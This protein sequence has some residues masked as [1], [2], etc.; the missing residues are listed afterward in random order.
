MSLTDTTCRQ[1]KPTDKPYKLADGTL[2]VNVITFSA[3][4]GQALMSL[5][6]GESVSLAGPLTVKVWTDRDG[7]ARPSLDMQAH[8][9]LTAYQVRKRR[10]AAGEEP[11]SEAEH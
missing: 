7:V 8:A 6:D 2:F 1:A 4:A 10:Q 9:V 11:P 3:S 5:G